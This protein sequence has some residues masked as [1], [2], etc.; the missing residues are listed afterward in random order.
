MTARRCSTSSA[1]S[2]ATSCSRSA[3]S[4]C[5]NGPRGFSIW[6]RGRACGCSRAS[7]AST[8]SCRCSS[9]RRATATPRKVRERI[10]ALLADTYNGRIV[11]FYPYFP[12]GPLVRV[13][14]IVGR[15]GGETPHADVAD[16]ERKIA[17]IVR[18]W[19][20]RLADA[21]A[22]QGEGAEAAARQ[23]RR[24]LL[25][26]IR[27][28]LLGRAGAAGHRAHR[29][30]RARSAGRHRFPSRSRARRPPAST[31]PSIRWARRSPCPSACRCWRTWASR[32]STSAPIT[33]GRGL[34]TAS[35]T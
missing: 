19:E 35:A 15:Y 28:D 20:D 26:R 27:G 24:G 6:R 1:P 2:P 33:S 7:T 31:R 34:P 22:G 4:S 17:D 8:A 21:I 29:A 32:P 30:A 9:M 16:L 13:Q 25:G 23:V 18:T 14:F 3:S 12:E 11:A 10:G 5:R